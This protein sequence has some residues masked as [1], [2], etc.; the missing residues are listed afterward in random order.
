MDYQWFPGHMTKAMRQMKE[1][2]KLIDA[3]ENGRHFG[4]D[5]NTNDGENF[6]VIYEET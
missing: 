5:P 4:S 3:L 6:R 2:M 1:D